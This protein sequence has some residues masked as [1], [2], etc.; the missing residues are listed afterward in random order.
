MPTITHTIGAKPYSMIEL[1]Q[2]VLESRRKAKLRA[3]RLPLATA[4]ECD[5]KTGVSITMEDGCRVFI[6][7]AEFHELRGATH[8]ELRDVVLRIQGHSIEWPQLDM[9]FDICERLADLFG[10]RAIMAETFDSQGGQTKSR[11]KSASSRADGLKGG[12]P[13]KPVEVG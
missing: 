6:P 2:M 1:K 9:R 11:A 5:P 13:R 3:K 12:R 7:L 4:V 8:S 10:M